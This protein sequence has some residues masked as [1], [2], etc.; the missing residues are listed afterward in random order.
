VEAGARVARQGAESAQSDLGRERWAALALLAASVLLGMS[1]WFT[2]NAVSPE[3]QSR[4]GIDASQVGWLTGV[5]QLGFVCGTA[6]SALLNLA[7]IIPSRRYFAVCAALAALANASLLVAPGY[8]GA[9]ATRFLTGLFLAGV[10]PPAMKMTAT[11]FRSGR[12]L[13]IGSVVGAL[14]VGKAAPYLLK[15]IGGAGAAAVVLGASGAG[16]AASALVGTL[17][18]DGPYPFERRPFSWG[19]VGRIVRDRRTMLATGGYLGH[20]WELYAMW[21]WVPAFLFA[22][23]AARAPEASV[24]SPGV[25]ELIAFGAIAAGGA[26]CVWGGWAADRLGR[27]RVTI[28]SM[29]VSGV[30]CLLVG[31]FFAGPFLL[32]APLVWAWGFF[33]VADSAQFSALVTEVAPREGVGTALTL[34][35]S[36]GFLLTMATIQLVPLLVQRGG[37]AGAFPVL[38]V[39][40]ACGIWA[41]ARLLRLRAG[42][43]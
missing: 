17:Y 20:M 4:W 42:Q 30:C 11:W 7:D 33:V 31:F 27:E 2:A 9:L 18:R 12:G 19:L 14:T 6:L 28:L 29:A 13:A 22:S 26:G 35:T 39:G 5:V 37:W 24:P 10:Y 1:G 21:T 16:F 34:Q 23:A 8:P 40:P 25:L 3:L 15:A 43:G 41:M 38:A 32:L 36:I